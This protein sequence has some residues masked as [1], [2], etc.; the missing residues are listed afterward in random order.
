MDRDR[1]KLARK[2]RLLEELKWILMFAAAVYVVILLI[3]ARKAPPL[4]ARLFIRKFDLDWDQ[5][6]YNNFND[7]A[8]TNGSTTENATNAVQTIKKVGIVVTDLVNSREEIFDDDHHG[9]EDVMRKKA[10]AA[11]AEEEVGGVE[12]RF[13]F[14]KMY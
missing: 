14:K 5:E 12:V 4:V 6:G 7:T 11:D 10:A 8:T 13:S 1:A 2:L 9:E 3:S